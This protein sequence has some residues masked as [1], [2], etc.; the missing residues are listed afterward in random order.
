MALRMIGTR[1][2]TGGSSGSE[3]LGR[4]AE[5]HKVFGD[6]VGLS[7]FFIP[8]SKLPRLPPAVKGRMGFTF[9]RRKVPRRRP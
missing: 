1:I 6:L 3:Y 2:G 5:R 9:G 4:A 7:S 8:R